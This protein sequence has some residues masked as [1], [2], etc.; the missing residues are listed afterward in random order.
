MR[1]EL[2]AKELQG[3]E[4]TLNTITGC[5]VALMDIL[6]ILTDEGFDVAVI[7]M[8]DKNEFNFSKWTKEDFE[9]IESEFGDYL[10]FTRTTNGGLLVEMDENCV[11]DVLSIYELIAQEIFKAIKGLIFSIY[12]LVKT[13]IEPMMKKYMK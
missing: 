2:T 6:N 9:A 8:R 13:R 1:I 5:N 10:V 4:N 7:E 11:V 12:G 3:F